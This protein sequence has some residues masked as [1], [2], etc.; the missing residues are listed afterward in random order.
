M[1]DPTEP[2]HLPVYNLYDI[3]VPPPP[4]PQHKKRSHKIFITAVIALLLAIGASVVGI[5]YA[6][7]HSNT[8]VPVDRIVN[9]PVPT[10]QAIQVTP[11]PTY[12]QQV[13]HTTPP[14]T[15]TTILSTST[16]PVLAPTTQGVAPSG[17]PVD[18]T[19]AAIITH[20]QTASAIDSNYFPTN[21][22]SDFAIGQTVYVTFHLTLNGQSGYAEAKLYSD[23]T[24]IG[25][26]ILMVQSAYDH[27]Y[28]N[29]QLNQAA[30]GTIE[31]YWC[32]QTD[33]SDAKLATF[34]T[35]KVA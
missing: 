24:Y 17:S 29:A 6:E 23:T 3:P 30:T 9:T 21:L 18:P 13:I 14:P 2:G 22:T 16:S 34:I 25:N 8:P 20:A 35:F 10:H 19:A 31:L 26:K 5:V 28:F 32:M 12:V 15:P 4:P 1:Y 7:Q 27:G 11:T 33:C